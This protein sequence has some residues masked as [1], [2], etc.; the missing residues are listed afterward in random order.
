MSSDVIADENNVSDNDI[1]EI[2]NK[3]GI[4]DDDDHGQL[5]YLSSTDDTITRLVI[6]DEND[7][8]PAEVE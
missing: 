2:T 3:N 5:I 4:N 1:N 6:I 7:P 8:S